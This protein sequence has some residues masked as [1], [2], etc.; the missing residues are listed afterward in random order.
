MKTFSYAIGRIGTESA[1]AVGPEIKA[2]EDKGY[3]IVRLNIGEPGCNISRLAQAAAIN[4]LK[5]NQTHYTPAGG[6][7]ILRREIAEYLK[8]TRNVNFT[9]NDVILAPGGKPVI[10]GTIMILLNPGDEIIYPTPGYPI[11]ESMAAFVG[12]KLKPLLLREENGFRFDIADLKKLVSPKTKLLILNSPSNPTGGVLEKEDLEKIAQLSKKYD[13]YILS[14]EVYSRLVFGNDFPKVKY[15]GNNLPISPSIASLPGMEEGTII[16]DGFS[17]TYAMTGLRLGFAASKNKEF[18]NKF[19]TYAINIWSC[20]PQPCM[21]AAK[22][23]LVKDQREA[24]KEIDSYRKKRDIC[25]DLINKIDGVKCFSPNGSFYLFPNVTEVCKK[26][27]F[28]SAEELRKYLLHH[29]S[30]GKK[31]VAVLSRIH[32]GNKLKNEKDEYIRLSIA[33][34]LTDL[35]EGIKRIKESLS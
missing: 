9:E 22:A 11:Y 33:G 19:L 20:L 17:K 15:K 28:K 4:S 1:F 26:K 29:D 8:A 2:W 7:N 32:F 25:V 12:A 34:S 5:N 23:V 18:M 24:A 3:N 31:G 14:D 21:E 6:D 27:G 13:F 35:K 30:K 10:A 16:L